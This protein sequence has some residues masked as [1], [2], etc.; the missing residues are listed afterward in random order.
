MKYKVE[1]CVSVSEFE[2]VSVLVRECEC[3]CL[4]EELRG[5]RKERRV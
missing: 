5:E 1:W 3:E 4:L 2:C